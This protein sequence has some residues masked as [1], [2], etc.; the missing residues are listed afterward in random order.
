[1]SVEEM[2]TGM[3]LVELWTLLF[4]EI[5]RGGGPQADK[6]K[7]DRLASFIHWMFEDLIIPLIKVLDN[8]LLIFIEQFLRDR[9]NLASKSDFL[10]F[11]WYVEPPDTIRMDQG[12]CSVT[13]AIGG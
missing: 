8:I 6:L 2:L 11:T 12:T 4:K 7:K 10:L 13:G 9:I 1:M 3:R 5:S